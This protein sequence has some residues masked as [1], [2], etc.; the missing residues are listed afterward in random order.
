MEETSQ[1]PRINQVR[2]QHQQQI[3]DTKLALKIKN[4]KRSYNNKKHKLSVRAYNSA[5]L[6]MQQTEASLQESEAIIQELKNSL[7][8][9]SKEAGR[10]W[11]S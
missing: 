7:V 9:Q 6:S 1:Q 3:N 10:S 4:L 11:T 2:E 5:L 8:Q